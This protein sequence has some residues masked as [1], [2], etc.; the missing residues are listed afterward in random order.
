MTDIPYQVTRSYGQIIIYL[1]FVLTYLVLIS[2]STMLF[3]Y[4]KC[5]AFQLPESMGGGYQKYLDMDMRVN[6]A[7]SRYQK[8]IVYAAAM[9]AVYPI[10]IPALYAVMLW[11]NRKTLGNHAAM[12]REAANGWP[13]VHIV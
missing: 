6:C 13:T 5:T 8:I 3:N 2:T 9:I 4:F 11:R 1:F 10:G 7:S 12:E